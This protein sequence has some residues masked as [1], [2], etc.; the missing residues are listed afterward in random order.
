MYHL[1]SLTGKTDI[2]VL[3]KGSFVAAIKAARRA[4]PGTEVVTTITST[5]RD[6]L[7]GKYG[8]PGMPTIEA[9][10]A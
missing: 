5:D 2:S 10:G 6:W 1:V 3:A 7:E 9:Q 8:F 4:Y